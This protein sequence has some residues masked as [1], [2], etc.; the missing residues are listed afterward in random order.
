MKTIYEDIALRTGGDI[1]IGVVGPVRCGKSTFIKEFMEE[2]VIP[3][4]TNEYDKKRAMD[5]LPQSA[6]GKTVMTTEP[7]FIPDESVT[8]TFGE[9]AKLKVKMV[10]CVGYMIPGALGSTEEGSKRM[11]KTP[12]SDEQM[13]FEE[14]AELGTKK[15][16]SDHAT[17][18]VLVTCDGS[19]GEIARE[20][21][22][23]A[24]EKAAAELKSIGKPFA[25]VLNS[26]FPE[27]EDAEKLAVELEKKYSAPVALLNC[28]DIDFNDVTHILEMIMY[29]FPTKEISVS[30]PSWLGALNSDHKLIAK[31]TE[32]IRDL[33]EKN[34]C[35]RDCNRFIYELKK[36]LDEVIVSLFE[37]EQCHVYRSGVDIGIGNMSLGLELPESI[38]Y[39]V[40]CEETGLEVKSQRELIGVLRE[41]ANAKKEFDKYSVAISELE[42]NGYG[43]VLPDTHS[44]TLEEPQIIRQAGS[45]GVKLK[46]SATSVHMIKANIQTE[47]NPIVGT[48]EQSEEL[49]KRLMSEFEEDPSKI[50]A[51]NI[52]GKSLYELLNDGLHTKL[53]H[54]S[55]DSK[56]KLSETLSRVINEG[57]RGLICIIL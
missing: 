23:L 20:A 46:A 1:Y 35:L 16:I 31:I 54:L 50:W 44:M 12:W 17:V 24:E 15:V 53:A 37:G 3:G 22:V 28:K 11:V 32:I 6:D 34:K 49:V 43:I 29:E 10:D 9:N 36:K 8:V 45:Y 56:E 18:G 48:E 40:I 5:E 42:E 27:S 30:L 25:I 13:T 52:F 2:A 19:F 33:S 38:Y 51:S 21:Y 41:L 26:A 14:A 39:K 7:K 47:I 57:S 55:D 4:I